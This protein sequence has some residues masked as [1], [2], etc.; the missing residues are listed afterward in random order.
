[1]K[2]FNR[3]TYLLLGL[4]VI[5]SIV[6]STLI[7]NL[8]T[9][10]FDQNVIDDI[11]DGVTTTTVQPATNEEPEGIENIL[12]QEESFIIPEDE[13]SKIE[14][15]LINN[16]F[17]EDINDFDTYLLIGSDE[18]SEKVAE[19][20]GKIDGKRADVIILGLVSKDTNNIS[21]LSFPRDLLIK[22]SFLL[23]QYNPDST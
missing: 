12:N 17:E 7:P 10:E 18:R 2:I 16:S 5:S 1:M 19:T 11:I 20:R 14:Q 23:K 8:Q 3:Y 4:I 6:V 9:E 22:K 13:V 21:L 15:I